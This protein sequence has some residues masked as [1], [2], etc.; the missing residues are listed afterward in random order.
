MRRRAG[1]LTGLQQLL[2]SRIV[3]RFCVATHEAAL[4]E[5]KQ[6]EPA[7]FV[8]PSFNSACAAQAVHDRRLDDQGAEFE[9]LFFHL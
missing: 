3:A 2:L 5:Q 9:F 6:L 4:F 8:L 1:I 7:R